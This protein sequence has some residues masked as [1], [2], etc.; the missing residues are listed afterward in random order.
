MPPTDAH[1]LRA[2][3]TAHAASLVLYARTWLDLTAA[4]DAV[5]EAFVRLIRQ[6]PAPDIPRAWLFRV[7]RNLAI[8]DRRQIRRRND[9]ALAHH[10]PLVQHTPRSLASAADVHAILESLEPATRE[11]LVM[12]AWGGLTFEEIATLTAT[13]LT[14][15][16]RT[17]QLGLATARKQLEGTCQTKPR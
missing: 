14:T 16:H 7:V 2:I 6:S 3:F 17:Y 15:V 1:Q 11:I 8:S 13:P 12:K 5:Q 9:V 4:E 10:Q